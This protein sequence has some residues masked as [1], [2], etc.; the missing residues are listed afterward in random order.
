MGNSRLIKFQTIKWRNLLSTGNIFTEI[1]L[2]AHQNALIVGENGAGKSTILDALTFALFGKPFR[3]INKGS[4]VNSV[5]EKGCE[6]R[7]TFSTNNKNY[8]IVRGIKP[9]I[10][11]IYCD[12]I[13]I[14]QDS[15]SKDYQDYLEKVILKMTLKSFTQIVILGSAS[16]T[17][18]MQ[19]TPNERRVVIEDLLDIQIFSVMNIVA[20]QKLQINKENIDQNRI[21]NIGKLDKKSFIEKNITSLEQN[22]ELR[23]SE[24]RESFIQNENQYKDILVEITSL[25]TQRDA[26]LSNIEDQSIQKAKHSKLI[27]LHSKIE[28][29]LNR[30]QKEISFYC[31]N[32]DCPTCRQPIVKSFKDKIII[33]TITKVD[34]FKDGLTK[35]GT[36]I[37]KCV[38]HITTIEKTISKINNI[39][40]DITSNKTKLSAI[41]STNNNI[42]DDINRI[43]H[44][45]NTLINNKKELIVVVDELEK[46]KIEKEALLNDRI[47]IET[48]INLLKDGGIKTKIIKQYLPV[49]NKLINKY[50]AQMGFFVNF[51]INEQ[52]EE[53]IKSRYRDEF[54]YHNFSE[55]EKTRIDLALLLTWRAIAKMRNSVN[56]NLLVLDEVFDGSLDFNGTDELMKIMWAMTGDSNV[57]VISHKTDQMLDK[58]QKV[59]RFEKVKNFSSLII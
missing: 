18:F 59:Y 39:K 20:K 42:E 56:C 10:F 15:A 49:I 14:N 17:P 43:K 48:S 54:S 47:L 4:L 37:D 8:E 36:E 50:L 7:I 19:L 45:D 40:N 31:D 53:T 52:F 12:N 58:F 51:N 23:E 5:N 33:E 27:S 9:N 13:M 55:G 25:E 32:D 26:L 38:D 44:S 22:N 46:Y 6:V 29:N 21:T 41:V 24:L 34:E 1:Q 16:F 3:K 28:N 30:A 2:D 11:E 57:F 35:L